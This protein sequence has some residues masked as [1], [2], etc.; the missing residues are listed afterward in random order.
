MHY[1]CS[2]HSPSIPRPCL[3]Y[4]AIQKKCYL[5]SEEFGINHYSLFGGFPDGAGFSLQSFF[6]Q[7]KISSPIPK[8]RRLRG[9]SEKE[10]W[11]SLIRN[12]WGLGNRHAS[13]FQPH[14][15]R[16][17]ALGEAALLQALRGR[18]SREAS[19]MV[20]ASSRRMGI[21]GGKSTQDLSLFNIM[22]NL[23]LSH[24]LSMHHLCPIHAPS[25]PR[26]CPVYAPS[27]PHPF[28]V[29]APSMPRPFPIHSPSV[30]RLCLGYKAVQKCCLISE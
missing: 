4:K 9:L 2:I 7:K 29:Y 25:I 1:L 14:F 21:P 3:G 18:S 28:H 26:L 27:I 17:I 15:G 11:E 16:H 6:R 23:M 5:I 12:F 19:T 30:P 10:E 13:F 22:L 8:P 24:A 20:N